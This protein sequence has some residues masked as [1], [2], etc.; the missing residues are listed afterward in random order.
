[1]SG[2]RGVEGGG[3]MCIPRV[4]CERPVA[5]LVPGPRGHATQ[6]MGLQNALPTPSVSGGPSTQLGIGGSHFKRGTGKG[7]GAGWGDDCNWVGGQ[8]LCYL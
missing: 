8:P 1:M 3:G 7:G 6:P 4:P 2:A 5:S